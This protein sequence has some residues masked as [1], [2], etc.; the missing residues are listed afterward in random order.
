LHGGGHAVRGIGIDKSGANT[1][2]ITAS[3]RMLRLSGCPIA[4]EMM[5]G[6]DLDNI[7]MTIGP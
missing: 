1:A 6:T 7:V 4:K 3:N 2:G 5:R